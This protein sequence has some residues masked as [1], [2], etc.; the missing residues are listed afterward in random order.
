MMDT[1]FCISI[2]SAGGYEKLVQSPLAGNDSS[3]GAQTRLYNIPDDEH[4]VVAVSALGVNYADVCIRWGYY[5]SAKEYVGWPITPGFEF[6]GKIVEVGTN[7]SD[8]R[9]GDEVFGVTLF[10]AYSTRLRV[11]ARYVFKRPDYLSMQQAASFPCVGLTAYYA[12]HE[13]VHPRP[14]A[15]VLVHSAAGG[16]GSMLVQICKLAKCRVVGVVGSSHKVEAARELGCDDVIDKSKE[17]LWL[18]CRQI[19]PSG[20]K[21]IFDANGSTI[22]KSYE[23]IQPGGKLVVYGFHSIFPKEG[24]QLGVRQTIGL[25]AQYLTTPSFNPFKMVAQNKSVLAFNLS[26]LFNEIEIFREAMD[27][28][29]SWLE[30]KELRIPAIETVPLENV[31]EAHRRLESG[32]TIGKLVLVTPHLDEGKAED[33]A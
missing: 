26:F 14:G 27:Q 2:P 16:V 7:C 32:Q 1:E 9:I 20:F 4:V 25:V 13:L 15:S 6:S 5:E 33:S 11:P 29:L 3:T 10:G 28:I 18:R 30:N 31:A 19:E 24:G 8:L 17:D 21:V 12:V 22:G 23:N